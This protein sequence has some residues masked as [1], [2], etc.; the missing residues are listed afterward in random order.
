[1]SAGANLRHIHEFEPHH[2]DQLVQLLRTAWWAS[3]R[4]RALTE[5]LLVGADLVHGIVE[6]STGELLAFARVLTDSTA[7]ALVLDVVVHPSAR[8]RGI[9]TELMARLLE[10]PPLPHVDSIELVCQPDVV[11]FYE[12]LGFSTRVGESRL[13]RRTANARLMSPSSD[14]A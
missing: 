11:A 2:V 4:D 3:N 10:R 13:M 7:I 8:G 5:K 14:D 9:G 6:I 12:R 1:M